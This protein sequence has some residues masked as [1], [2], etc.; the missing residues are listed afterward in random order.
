MGKT[1]KQERD[2]K[3]RQREKGKKKI[4]SKCELGDFDGESPQKLKDYEKDGSADKL[5]AY[6]KDGSPKRLKDYER[7]DLAPIDSAAP[8]GDPSK[9]IGAKQ[10]KAYKRYQDEVEDASKKDI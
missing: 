5:K 9:E 4:K 6:E 3:K 2:E 10:R 1:K 7:K 8:V